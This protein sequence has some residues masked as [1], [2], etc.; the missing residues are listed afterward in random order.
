MVLQAAPRRLHLP[1]RQFAL[2]EGEFFFGR[3]QADVI[4][5]PDGMF[6]DVQVGGLAASRRGD[7]GV[8]GFVERT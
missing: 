2:I 1:G 7:V 4:G 8:A 5:N 6:A 3:S